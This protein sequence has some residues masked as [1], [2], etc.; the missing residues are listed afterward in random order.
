MMCHSVVHRKDL[1]LT[2]QVLEVLRFATGLDGVPEGGVLVLAV[3]TQE[4]RTYYRTI[5]TTMATA[6]GRMQQQETTAITNK[7]CNTS[8]KNHNTNT[9][10]RSP[11][12][13]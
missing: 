2:D 4:P 8:N 11:C 6:R 1:V 5:E 10:V 12:E 7:N 3:A 13:K 9:Y